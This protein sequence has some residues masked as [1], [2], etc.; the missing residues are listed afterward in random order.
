[1]LGGAAVRVEVRAAS[2]RFAR[3]RA[4]AAG[5]TRYFSGRPCKHGHV[6]ERVTSN[7][8][9]VECFT[10]NS[11]GW[12]KAH[13][14]AFRKQHAA[15]YAAYGHTRRA[16]MQAPA[17]AQSFCTKAVY[18]IAERL[19]TTTGIQFTVDHVVPLQGRKVSGLHVR[20]NLQILTA[21]ENFRKH[22]KFVVT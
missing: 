1:M 15:R 2:P 14:G 9:C 4:K 3:S 10:G 21:S 8:W 5:E 16:K 22:N 13:P 17:W 11:N 18:R 20:D 19:R 7:G 6:A 12:H